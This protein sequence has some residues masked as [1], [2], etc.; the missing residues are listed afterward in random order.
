[1]NCETNHR[2]AETFERN[3]RQSPGWPI[4]AG[5][6]AGPGRRSSS[7]GPGC[8]R[9]HRGREAGRAEGEGAGDLMSGVLVMLVT[10]ISC[11]ILNDDKLT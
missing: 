9:A 4:L 2:D 6:W 3:S 5:P 8:A 1:M 10:N 7:G 11:D